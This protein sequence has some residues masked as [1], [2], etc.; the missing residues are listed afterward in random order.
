MN[1]IE[2]IDN[3]IHIKN[4]ANFDL[5]QTLDCGQ[6]F[7]WSQNENGVWRGIAFGKYIELCQKDGDIII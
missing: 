7:R 5:A 2:F 3:E 4:V 6:A 1:N